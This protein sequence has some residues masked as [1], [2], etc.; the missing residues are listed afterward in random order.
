[1]SNSIKGVI[2]AGGLGTRFLPV[3]KAVAKEMLPILDTPAIQYIVEEAAQAGL[4]DLTIITS[5]NKE[6]LANYFG[7]VAKF[8]RRLDANNEGYPL[9]SI[10]HMQTRANLSYVTQKEPLGLG[11]AVLISRSKIRN[12]PFAVLLPDD[13][14]VC[15]DQ[16]SHSS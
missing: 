8:E 1:M 6:S 11:H 3:T 5:P 12:Q 10:R 2:P 16:P 14:M 7:D 15:E 4:G 13:V 9:D